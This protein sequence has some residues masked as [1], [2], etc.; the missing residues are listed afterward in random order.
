MRKSLYL[1]TYTLYPITFWYISIIYSIEKPISGVEGSIIYIYI[2]SYTAWL[3]IKLVFISA[4]G[5]ENPIR[6]KKVHKNRE[7]KST[8]DWNFSCL[9]QDLLS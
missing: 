9:F 4:G 8:E 5:V 3:C 2:H 1:P 6:N 7:G